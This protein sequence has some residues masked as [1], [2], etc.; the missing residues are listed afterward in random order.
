MLQ[1][2][3]PDDY[4][5]ATGQSHTVH[6]LVEIA[7]GELGLDWKKHVELDARYLRPT[8]VDAL[9]GDAS[10]ARKVL[11]WRPKMDFTT[12][13]KLMVQHDLGLAQQEKTLHRAG[14]QSPARG[15]ASTGVG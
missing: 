14:Y 7:F 13:I 5:V 3:K 11:S 2:D 8:E 15:A 12:L 1:Q 6:Q 4:V 9:E 10:K